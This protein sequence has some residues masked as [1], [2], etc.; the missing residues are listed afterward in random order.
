MS[1]LAKYIL[2]YCMV[3][4]EQELYLD[5]DKDDLCNEGHKSDDLYKHCLKIG[6]IPYLW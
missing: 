5:I 3:G 1:E 6:I 2:T 4:E